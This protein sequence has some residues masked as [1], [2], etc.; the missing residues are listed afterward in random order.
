MKNQQDVHISC[1]EVN[2]LILALTSNVLI[3][4]VS[5]LDLDYN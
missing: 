2:H 1:L 3:N 4:C 5:E